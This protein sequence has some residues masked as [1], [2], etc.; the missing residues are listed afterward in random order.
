MRNLCDERSEREDWQEMWWY[1]VKINNED[2]GW[3]KERDKLED[4]MG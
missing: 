1:R 3:S 4:F 2:G